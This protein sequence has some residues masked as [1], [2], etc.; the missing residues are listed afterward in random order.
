M[1]GCA[2]KQSETDQKLAEMQKQLDDTKKQLEEAKATEAQPPVA[3][4]AATPVA[5]HRTTRENA[6]AAAPSNSSAKPPASET[7]AAIA[8]SKADPA[9]SGWST[10]QPKVAAPAAQQ[11]AAPAK[12][13][14]YVI[15]AGAEISVRTTSELSTKKLADGAPFDCTLQNDLVVDGVVIAERGSDATGVV[16]NSDP[17][18]RVKGVASLQVALRSITGAKGNRIDVRT[19]PYVATAKGTVKKDAVKT[20][21]MSGVG[22]AIGAIAGGGKGAAIGAGAGAAA[23]VGTAMATRGEAATIPAESVLSFRTTAPVTVPNR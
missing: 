6:K 12:P 9:T 16:V 1:S 15:P 14:E 13:R 20:G 18:G 23:G 7:A 11:H 2:S 21:I 22:A 10:P 17:G 19:D 4:P 8:P 5:A 3:A